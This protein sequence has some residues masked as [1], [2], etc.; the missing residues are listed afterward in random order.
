MS[1]LPSFAAFFLLFV[2]F[3]PDNLVYKV[4]AFVT[5]W[6]VVLVSFLLYQITEFEDEKWCDA[7]TN[8]SFIEHESVLLY[9]I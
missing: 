6:F 4:V 3:L 7:T 5:G 2:E 8:D 1:K 9:P